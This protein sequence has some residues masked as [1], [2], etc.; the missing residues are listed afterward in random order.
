MIKHLFA[1]AVA[2]AAPAA[3]AADQSD[4]WFA[5]SDHFR[6]YSA[7]GEDT[8]QE[9]AMRLEM[10]DMAMRIYTGVA[11][12]QS[13]TTPEVA[14]PTLFQFGTNEDIADLIGVDGVYGFFVP[15]AGNSVAFMP[16]ETK[17]SRRRGGTPGTR[18][19]TDFNTNNIDPL[20]VIQHEYTHYFMFQHA[21]AAYPA[22]YQEGLAEVFGMLRIEDNRFFV[23]DPPPHRMNEIAVFKVDA[24]EMFR[25][26]RNYVNY[27]H[28]GHGWLLT[29]YL[30][31]EPSR[32]GQLAAFLK[33]LNS[34]TDSL[35]AAREAFGD[36]DQLS[37]ELN[38]YRKERSRGL[39][40]PYPADTQP[41][42]K[43]RKLSADEIAR[44][45]LFVQSQAGVTKEEAARQLS[46]AN[47]ILGQHPH[48]LPVLLEAA[49][50]HT[51]A[52]QYQKGYD[53]YKE[54]VAKDPK[55]VAGNL[56]LARLELQFAENDPSWLQTARQSFLRVNEIEN[57]EPNALAGYYR[58][59]VLA[60][61]TPPE[62]AVIALE[63]A[64]IRAP[65]DEDIR[66]TLAYQLITE[67]R[68][69]EA[70]VVLGPILNTPHSNKQVRE[71]RELATKF[72]DGDRDPLIAKLKPSLSE[73][74]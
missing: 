26:V 8:A 25:P 18:H 49:E 50:V 72:S 4:W 31:F 66:K 3:H 13:G 59:F 20:A 32:S 28:Y 47:A 2:L 10:L 6:V 22:W 67:K 41:V 44:M 57:E 36:L 70:L 40:V 55:S 37:K 39:A 53:L 58:T 15:R 29:N 65:F 43:L 35:V 38:A 63:G 51:D 23:G 24:E 42:I 21:P 64:Y 19:Y 12:D 73:D 9:L 27:P 16:L 71:L 34:G 46:D 56:G 60:G 14:K 33:A 69:E 74:D 52:G 45:D 48:S 7:G 1:L 5:E 11:L 61:V 62:D 30:A 17:D 54:A 68:D